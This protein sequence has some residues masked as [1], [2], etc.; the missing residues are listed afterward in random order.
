MNFLLPFLSHAAEYNPEEYDLGI[1][2]A[3]G[4]GAFGYAVVFLGLVL[5][6]SVVICIGKI[7]IARDR[8]AA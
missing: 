6:M 1:M 5:L 2:E 4:L 7:F 3:L 8:K